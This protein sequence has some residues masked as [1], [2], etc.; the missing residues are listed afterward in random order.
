MTNKKFDNEDTG[1]FEEV[2][3][4]EKLNIPVYNNSF[5][6]Q[7]DTSVGDIC[8]LNNDNSMYIYT[9]QN[10]WTKLI[11]GNIT[12]SQLSVNSNINMGNYGI[13]S[14]KVPDSDS[15]LTN[16]L[17]CD[18][19]YY[20]RNGGTVFGQMFIQNGIKL[21]ESL[22]SDNGNIQFNN[23]KFEFR[24]NDSWKTLGLQSIVKGETTSNITIS[25]L[26]IKMNKTTTN[27]TTIVTSEMINNKNI[28]Y[29]NT[30]YANS[31]RFD[32]DF[33]N[34]YNSIYYSNVQVTSNPNENYV[35]QARFKN[36]PSVSGTNTVIIYDGGGSP[37]SSLPDDGDY[38]FD[39][40]IIGN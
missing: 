5:P 11:S 30:V 19:N 40:Q 8:L 33:Y 2:I 21:G 13:T 6:S 10:S 14:S 4:S 28:R 24:E 16:R 9:L 39:V 1:I 17:F 23:N 36:Y 31:V 22:A 3:V 29:V 34:N 18:S 7:S 35:F 38:Y 25:T 27:N 20:S 12:T 15:S 37:L 26:R 32:F